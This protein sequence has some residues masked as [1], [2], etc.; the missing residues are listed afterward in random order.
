MVLPKN[1]RT[2]PDVC[3]LVGGERVRVEEDLAG[4]GVVKAREELDERRFSGTVYAD[5]N[6]ELAWVDREGNI[7]ERVFVL[8]GV[9]ERDVSKLR[10]R[11]DYSG[12]CLK[13]LT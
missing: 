4:G 13:S 7:R 8:L 9:S 11:N 6:D 12:E 1:S 2:T 5:D 10:F 3:Q